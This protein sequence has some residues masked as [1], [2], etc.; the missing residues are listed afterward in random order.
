MKLYP[1][2]PLALL[3]MQYGYNRPLDRRDFP[4]HHIPDWA[5]HYVPKQG[6]FRRFFGNQHGMANLGGLVGDTAI[7][8]DTF[9]TNQVSTKQ[10]AAMGSVAM[11]K[12]GRIFRY[13]S[14]GAADLVVGNIVQSAAPIPN[15]LANTPPVVAAG[16]TSFSYTPGAT[17]GA[18]NLYAE[19]TLMIDT[20][21]G[22]GYTYRISGHPTITASVAFNLVLDPDEAIVVALTA[23]SRVGLHHNPYKTVIQTPTT[24]TAKVVGGAVNI[25]TANTVSENYGWIQTRGPFAALINGTPAITSPVANSGTTAGAVDVWTTAAAAVVVTPCG[26]MMQVGV[27]GKNNAVFLTLD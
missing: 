21:P 17:G 4:Y 19:G 2:N 6:W 10:T 7:A 25:I 13:A 24:A 8:Q 1:V 20:T 22:N 18:A 12:D 14:A 5:G 23:S 27:S 3:G 26:Y 11:S 16:A 15:H 9:N